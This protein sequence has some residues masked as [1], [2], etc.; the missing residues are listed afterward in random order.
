[1]LNLFKHLARRSKTSKNL[2]DQHPESILSRTWTRG[3]G[4]QVGHACEAWIFLVPFWDVFYSAASHVRYKVSVHCQIP[5]RYQVS[6]DNEYS[7]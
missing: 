7:S 5:I 3:Q 6:S 1:M 2:G 4:S